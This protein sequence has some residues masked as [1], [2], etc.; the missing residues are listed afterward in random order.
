MR[1]H[2]LGAVIV[3]CAAA[4]CFAA[5]APQPP[6]VT[7]KRQAAIEARMTQWQEGSAKAKRLADNFV[8]AANA[9]HRYSYATL[10]ARAEDAL[11][12]C[13]MQ[14]KKQTAW[15]EKVLGQL[16]A[17]ASTGTVNAQD[18][19]ARAAAIVK[20][21]QLRMLYTYGAIFPQVL[22]EAVHTDNTPSGRFL[23]GPDWK[24]E[25]TQQEMQTLY[26]RYKSQT[27]YSSD[28]VDN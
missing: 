28:L 9:D 14:E 22:D 27:G 12:M 10:K 17:D 15:E 20:I 24:M 21:F 19:A 25:L 2:L 26:S 11:R 1:H 7:P 3:G 4:S 5:Q 16:G 23:A 18:K 8:S 13:A 6:A